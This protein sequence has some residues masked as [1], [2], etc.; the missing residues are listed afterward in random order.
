MSIKTFESLSDELILMIMEYSGDISNVLR[1]YFGLNQHFNNIIF[2]NYSSFMIRFLHMI[3]PDKDM[4]NISK[5]IL[6]QQFFN[7]LSQMKSTK[8]YAHIITYLQGF[9]EDHLQEKFIELGI[10]FKSKMTIFKSNHQTEKEIRIAILCSKI[11]KESYDLTNINATSDNRWKNCINLQK[12]KLISNN[13]SD[14]FSISVSIIYDKPL[15]SNKSPFVYHFMKIYKTWIVYA[16]DYVDNQSYNII[17]GTPLYDGF[18]EVL[19]QI[20]FIKSNQQ[21]YNAPWICPRVLIDTIIYFIQA[22]IYFSNEN[23]LSESNLCRL[24]KEISSVEWIIPQ[25]PWFEV[26]IKQIIKFIIDNYIKQLPGRIQTNSYVRSRF[27][28]FFRL[29][30]QYNRFNDLL[31]F[32]QNYFLRE[33]NVKGFLRIFLKTHEGR[34]C[35]DK[36][37]GNKIP[38]SWLINPKWLFYLVERNEKEFLEK[39]LRIHPSLKK[40]IDDEG[41]DLLLYACCKGT[42]RRYSMIKVLIEIFDIYYRR[43]KYGQTWMNALKMKHN[44]NLFEGLKRNGII[45][46]NSF[47]HIPDFPQMYQHSYSDNDP[48]S[49]TIRRK[50]WKYTENKPT[51]NKRYSNRKKKKNTIKN[52]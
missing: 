25:D 39:I 47:E 10:Q 19:R 28:Y 32:Y 33:T 24:M 38:D 11:R 31:F 36:F 9:L 42:G 23:H 15:K 46:Q 27:I 22:L 49:R 20:K 5:S 35:L 40:T 51:K 14:P 44:I 18:R 17:N 1:T 43:N 34:H 8:N 6:C 45:N 50:I 7:N 3:V 52:A 13:I 2:D 4:K 16:I 37:L 30:S 26:I 12:K 29:L 48:F 21:K 41:N